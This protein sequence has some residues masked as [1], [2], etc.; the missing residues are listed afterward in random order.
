MH[1]LD[2]AIRKLRESDFYCF[3]YTSVTACEEEIRKAAK[4]KDLVE[5]TIRSLVETS[6][7]PRSPLPYLSKILNGLPDKPKEE[8]KDND[9][10]SEIKK[11]MSDLKRMTKELDNQDGIIESEVKFPMPSHLKYHPCLST[12]YKENTYKSV[13]L[14]A[15]ERKTSMHQI[16]REKGLRYESLIYGSGDYAERE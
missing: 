12:K 9:I 1:S 11:E 10:A 14:E 13:C 7:K 15:R 16:C 3:G 6:I 2:E 4:T 8:D 5:K